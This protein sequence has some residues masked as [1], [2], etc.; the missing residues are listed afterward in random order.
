LAAEVALHE[1]RL[2]AFFTDAPAGLV[3]LDM[4]WGEV[5]VVRGAITQP[6]MGCHGRRL[7]QPGGKPVAS[8]FASR[9][10]TGTSTTVKTIKTGRGKVKRVFHVKVI[11]IVENEFLD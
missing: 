2:N 4:H 10:I 3:L 9:L 1:Q 7:C 5:D 11:Q 6:G 8:H